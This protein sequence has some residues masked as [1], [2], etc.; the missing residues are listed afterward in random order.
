MEE[1]GI[2]SQDEIV[3]EYCREMG[4]DKVKNLDFYFAFS[5]F[6]IAAILQGV[7]K[8]SKQGV[9]LYLF[10]FL[11]NTICYFIKVKQAPLKQ[12]RPEN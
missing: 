12:N 1:L 11:T 10:A 9:V 5:F 8:R 4:I 3:E 7:Y 6:R 2:P